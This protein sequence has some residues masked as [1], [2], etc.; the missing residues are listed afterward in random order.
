M[1]DVPAM[2]IGYARVSTLDQNLDAQLDALRGAGCG[3][4]FSDKASGGSA[5]RL[6]LA[7]AL[8][9]CRAGDALVV[10]RLDRLGRSLADLLGIIEELR[11]RDIGFVSLTE[12][13]DASGAAGRLIFQIFGAV[14]EFERA[15]IRERTCAGLA[16][17]RARG[18]LGGRRPK[19]DP[20]QL[21][22]LRAMAA[23]PTHSRGALL[24]LFQISKSTFH[25]LVP[26]QADLALVPTLS[27]P[28]APTRAR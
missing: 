1:W 22:L 12:G 24:R 6:G 19:L 13:V 18:K 7:E 2:R 28:P 16:A 11:Q 20:D 27:E 5:A 9:F 4:I 10:A 15:L 26:C 25:R 17:A 23:D 14:A 3:Q 21:S 8:R